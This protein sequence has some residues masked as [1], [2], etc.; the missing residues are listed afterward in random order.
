MAKQTINIGTIAD[1]G[2]GDP[3]RTAFD[4]TNDNFDELYAA[5]E[6]A[7]AIASEMLGKRW[8][9]PASTNLTVNV[10]ADAATISAALTA[11]AR[12]DWPTDSSSVTIKLADGVY[13]YTSGH[14][15]KHSCSASLR[16]IGNTTTPANCKLQTST[17]GLTLFTVGADQA[18][19]V[20]GFEI[21]HTN[22]ATWTNTIAL[23]ADEG[24]Y[25][26][27]GPN[28][29]VDRFYWNLFSRRG[30]SC[31]RAEAGGVYKRAGDTNALAYQ[32]G[33]IDVS[34]C[35]LT[36]ANDA[37]TALG[38]GAVAE[39]G[40]LDLTNAVL[41][42]NKRAG[43]HLIDGYVRAGSTNFSNNT[44]D[45]VK[46]EGGQIDFTSG[47]TAGG[48]GG[49]GVAGKNDHSI[50]LSGVVA[51]GAGANGSG[52]FQPYFETFYSG[53]P[54]LIVRSPNTNEGLRFDSKGTGSHYFNTGGGT[55]FEV[56]N[57]ASAVNR[58]IISGAAAGG[59]A[60]LYAAGSDTD[61]S[62]RY[63][64]KGAGAHYFNTAGGAP[65]FEVFHTASAV[66]RLRLTG[67]ATGQTIVMSG[68]GT[69]S[70]VSVRFQ[71]Q[72]ATGSIGFR[73]GSGSTKFK[74]DDTGIAFYAAATV[75][76]QTVTGSRGGNAAVADLITKL[77]N[78]GIIID[79]TTP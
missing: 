74:V 41:T 67:A 14:V 8:L 43:C 66:N 12:W 20:D 24:G 10:P 64:T 13:V 55:Q 42:G 19:Y 71:P 18:L 37:T 25:I 48:N 44:N 1:D 52:L 60:R 21:S 7:A 72:G 65:Q 23:L 26:H 68:F 69:D 59:Q 22:L 28:M 49:Y 78:T 62:M 2:T 70:N 31:I 39:G 36:D 77:A 53:Q 57:T 9:V 4:K 76:Q 79:G 17:A 6:G 73:G 3:L 33:H 58:L 50:G 30:G 38:S 34:G 75:A 47:C 45:G 63:D 46:I 51:G 29:V 32:G 61:V 40:T 16:L 27:L 15:V 5:L 54:G 35:Q 56:S 11:I